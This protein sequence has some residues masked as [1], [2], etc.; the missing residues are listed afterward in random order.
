M[1]DVGCGSGRAALALAARG[2]KVTAV[3]PDASMLEQLRAALAGQPDAVREAVAVAD[4]TR[5]EELCK[6]LPPEAVGT[7]DAVC[8]FQA[9]H[10]FS[11]LDGFLRECK[12]LLRPG[13]LLALAWNDRRLEEEWVVE[14][15]GLIEKYNP[16]YN[17]AVKQND[18][19]DTL[20]AS[21]GLFVKESPASLLEFTHEVR[22]SD[23]EG[24]VALLDTYSYVRRALSEE[25]RS[26]LHE[27]ARELVRTHF[28]GESFSMPYVTKLF[29]LRAVNE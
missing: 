18:G 1:I 29:L 5:A 4:A 27:E 19:W 25:Q 12:A 7:L 9:A 16:E 15:E 2:A 13:G 24:L 21:T 26:E 14:L 23:A 8:A 20:V 11:P 6:G 17:R 10:W 3:D 22:Y 28:G